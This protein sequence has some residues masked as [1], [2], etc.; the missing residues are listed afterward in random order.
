[1]CELLTVFH[2]GRCKNS[3]VGEFT[4][5]NI[6]ILI[7]VYINRLIGLHYISSV[8]TYISVDGS[9]IYDR[10]R[11]KL[12]FNY[13]TQ[14]SSHLCLALD[15]VIGCCVLERWLFTSTTEE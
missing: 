3:H 9:H 12:Q 11:C 7:S 5:E 6:Y 15:V 14:Q 13:V 10:G 8:L 2:C 1:M 4:K